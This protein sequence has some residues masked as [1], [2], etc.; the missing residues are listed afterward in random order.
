MIPDRDPAAWLVAAAAGSL[1]SGLLSGLPLAG[2]AT[3]VLLED[4]KSVDS[5]FATRVLRIGGEVPPMGT[6]A[7]DGRGRLFGWAPQRAQ[8]VVWYLKG[9]RVGALGGPVY[10]EGSTIPA[11]IIVGPGDT[12]HVFERHELT[13]ARFSPELEFLGSMPLPGQPHFNGVVRMPG[14]EWVM[15]AIIDTRDRVG[16]PLH[17]LD[18]E[19]GVVR[20]FGTSLP[21]YR[22]DA[23]RLG[24]RSVVAAGD[25]LVWTAHLTEY[26]L[27]LWDTHNRLHKAFVRGAAMVSQVDP[28]RTDFAGRAAEP[29]VEEHPARCRRPALGGGEQGVGAVCRGG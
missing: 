8:G 24:V 10:S 11:A 14:G 9:A 19:G 16:W 3:A 6:F 23:K 13:L 28:Q 29:G 27:E 2:Q 5:V 12:I 7:M 22:A 25:D 20:S 1:V 18:D 4:C 15:S 26:R 17:L 21:F